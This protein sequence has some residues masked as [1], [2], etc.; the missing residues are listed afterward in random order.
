MTE[1]MAVFAPMARA[2]VITATA[3]KPRLFRNIRSPK[4]KSCASV[5]ITCQRHLPAWS[6][7]YGL[8]LEDTCEFVLCHGVVERREIA[9]LE[10]VEVSGGRKSVS[11]ST[12]QTRAWVPIQIPKKAG[13]CR[14]AHGLKV[15]GLENV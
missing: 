1:K 15:C 7:L 3:V 10:L 4:R 9:Q 6:W 12:N 13:R 8:A 5:P 2:S 11:S 14:L